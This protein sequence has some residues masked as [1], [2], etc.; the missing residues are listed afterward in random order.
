MINSNVFYTELEITISPMSTEVC[1]C[2]HTNWLIMAAPIDSKNVNK[3]T[4]TVVDE[5]QLSA[6]QQ[7]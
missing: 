7:M 1:L 4:V 5:L 6:L 3:E 2:V